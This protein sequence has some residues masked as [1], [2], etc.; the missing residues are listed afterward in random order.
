MEYEN[1]LRSLIGM[2]LLK[3]DKEKPDKVKD[4]TKA[5]HQPRVLKPGML[6]LD[7]VRAAEATCA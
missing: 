5:A 1:N 3:K 2:K 7:I 6:S 4:E